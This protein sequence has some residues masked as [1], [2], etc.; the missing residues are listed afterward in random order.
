MELRYPFVIFVGIV[1]SLILSFV[2]IKKKTGYKNGTKIANTKYA[3][4]LPYYNILMKKYKIIRFMILAICIICI[5][6]S[7]V[8]LSRVS[9]TENENSKIYSRDIMLCLDVS[10]SVDNVNLQL[11]ESYKDI[12]QNMEGERF[13]IS[14]FNG[15]SV[16]LVPLTD[17][18]EYVLN[19][20][21]TLGKAI[22]NSIKIYGS[23]Y[24]MIYNQS[25]ESRY[26]ESYLREGT[27][28]TNGSSLIGDGLASCVYDFPDVDEEQERTRI[29]IFSTDNQL[30]GEPQLTLKEAAEFCKEKN[31]IVFGIS[32]TKMVDDDR[33]EMKDAME[34]TGGEY[35]EEGSSGTVENIVSNIEEKGKSLIEVKNQT[36]QIDYPEIILIIT[37]ISISILFILSKKVKL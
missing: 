36:R 25:D 11:I 23:D 5:L 7:T 18:Y 14:I 22:E 31:I 13:G 9:K 34:L 27:L 32:P 26:Y 30:A 4:S 6:S 10:T 3:K 17:D 2:K 12:V 24:T 21:D 20:L 35:F 37:I 8:L 28:S 15:S 16:L 33:E 1:I 19:T 29:I